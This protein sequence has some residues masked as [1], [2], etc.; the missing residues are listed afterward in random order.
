MEL[1]DE[2]LIFLLPGV[3]FTISDPKD[4]AAHNRRWTATH[5][6]AVQPVIAAIRATC[7]ILAGKTSVCRQRQLWPKNGLRNNIRYFS[8]CSPDVWG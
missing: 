5:D 6:T 4:E 3:I 1:D 8:A 7:S 2:V